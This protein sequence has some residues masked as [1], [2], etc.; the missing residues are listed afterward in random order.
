MKS[1]HPD[2]DEVIRVAGSFG[3][4]LSREDAVVYRRELIA[5]LDGM[6]AFMRMP[7]EEMRPPLLYP[8]R[9]AGHR[10]TASEDPLR[11]WTWKCEV[12][13]APT[14]LLSGKTVSFKDHIAVA[15]MP[16]T[17]NAVAMEGYVPDFDA[18]VVTRVLA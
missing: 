4:T 15:G 8:Q 7:L 9:A 16:L 1:D 11:A 2:I 12:K 3:I 18:T 10:P 13:G 14:G 6:E 5:S 17:L